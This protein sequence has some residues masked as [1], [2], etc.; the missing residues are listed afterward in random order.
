MIPDEQTESREIENNLFMS[1]LIEVKENVFTCSF[2]N[3]DFSSKRNISAH[4]SRCEKVSEY[5]DIKLESYIKKCKDN[6][7]KEVEL[8]G[9]SDMQTTLENF[10]SKFCFSASKSEFRVI[11]DNVNL[12]TLKISN[13]NTKGYAVTNLTQ[14]LYVDIVKDVSLGISVLLTRKLKEN[15]FEKYSKYIDQKNWETNEYDPN[16]RIKKRILISCLNDGLRTK[17]TTL[18][19]LNYHT[20]YLWELD[21]CYYINDIL[22]IVGFDGKINPFHTLYRND[23]YTINLSKLNLPSYYT[24]NK[25]AIDFLHESQKLL[26]KEMQEI[27][28]ESKIL[29]KIDP[30]SNIIEQDILHAKNTIEDLKLKIKQLEEKL[31]KQKDFVTRDFIEDKTKESER[32]IVRKFLLNFSSA[33]DAIN[34]LQIDGRSSAKILLNLVNE[35]R[36]NLGDE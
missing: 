22:K 14:G 6:F 28:Y 30:L 17:K 3:K 8:R 7:D 33:E 16:S 25:K 2:C 21:A 5:I 23:Y 15:L 24:E 36:F 31:E 27:S 32:E 26:G 19:L 1:S 10:C 34:F 13:I 20:N 12:I 35:Y 11:E 18:D 4:L 9:I 29:I